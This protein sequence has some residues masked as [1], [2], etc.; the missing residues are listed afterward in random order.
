MEKF[1]IDPLWVNEDEAEAIDHTQYFVV[2]RGP[3]EAHLTHDGVDAAQEEM[4][5]GSFYVGANMDWPHLIENA[6]RAHAVYE[7]D[8]EYG[9]SRA[10]SSS[11]TS[12]R[13]G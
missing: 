5:I 10:R 1:R 12:S 7:R 9:S 8:K 11:S 3:Q 13:G 2:E 4:G 6:L